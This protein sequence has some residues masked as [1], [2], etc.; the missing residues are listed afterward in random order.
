MRDFFRFIK[1]GTTIVSDAFSSYKRVDQI[2]DSD[3][4]HIE[5]NHS[6]EFVDKDGNHTNNIEATWRVFR[7]GV[8]VR[9]RNKKILQPYLFEI[10]W[11]M[12]HLGCIWDAILFALKEVKYTPAQLRGRV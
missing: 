2:P 4:V 8:P 6:K 12:T 5:V 3:Y 9:C 1:P 10:M 7:A 11:R